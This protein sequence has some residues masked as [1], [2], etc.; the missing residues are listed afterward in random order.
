MTACRTLLLGHAVV[1]FLTI[2][3]ARAPLVACEIRGEAMPSTG[4]R[5]LNEHGD[6]I[7]PDRTVG[8]LRGIRFLQPEPG[9]PDPLTAKLDE[10]VRPWREGGTVLAAPETRP[11][12]WGRRQISL[13]HTAARHDFDLAWSLVRNGFAMAWPAELPPNCRNLYLQ[14]E[15]TARRS[16]TG[17]WT[18]MHHRALDAANGTDVALRAGQVAVMTGRISHVGQTR[19]AAYLNFGER[20]RGASA[21]LGLTTWRLIEAQGWTRDALKGKIVRVR[22]VVMEGRPARLLLADKAAIEFLN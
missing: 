4:M 2:A 20:G 21:E 6:V 1:L 9:Q 18:Q 16:K 8:R 13:V 3:A 17:R 7:L 11:D 10:L 22:G 12:R 5:G 15:E 14:A 19:R